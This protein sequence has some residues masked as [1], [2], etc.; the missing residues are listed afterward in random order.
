MS[1]PVPIVKSNDI[2]Q[3]H[4]SFNG[5]N[6]C[7][8]SFQP[9][10]PP[11]SETSKHIHTSSCVRESSKS[12]ANLSLIWTEPPT[13]VFVAKKYREPH[14]S[15][16]TRGLLFWLIETK[17]LTLYL[18]ET[19]FD[20]WKLEPHPSIKIWSPGLNLLVFSFHLLFFLF[21]LFFSFFSFLSFLF[22]FFFFSFFKKTLKK[23]V[24]KTKLILLSFLVEMEQSFMLLHYFKKKSHLSFHLILDL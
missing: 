3:N 23:K 15:Q 18:E 2:N 17:N 6:D 24:K 5:L 1:Q 13:T 10:S 21:F 12:L 11:K 16:K 20:D 22:F 7:Q 9:F 19:A 4:S 8:N 14:I